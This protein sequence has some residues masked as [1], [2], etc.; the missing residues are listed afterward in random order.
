LNKAEIELSVYERRLKE[1]IPDDPGLFAEVQ[2]I[3]SQRN[4][5]QVTVDWSSAPPMRKSSS[6]VCISLSQ[7]D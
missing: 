5:A 2:A 6:N 7:N 3:T 1:H 4:S